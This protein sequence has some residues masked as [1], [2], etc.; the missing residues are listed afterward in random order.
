MAR[1]KGLEGPGKPL[2]H[3]SGSSAIADKAR[4]DYASNHVFRFLLESHDVS[5]DRMNL[6]E[7]WACWIQA[8]I[9]VG[10]VNRFF[11]PTIQ[12]LGRLGC[13][14]L[15]EDSKHSIALVRKRESRLRK[16]LV[17]RRFT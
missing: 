17:N 12:G 11:M 5:H 8:S 1:I 7:R 16:A 13:E 4:D 14:I 2:L 6:D 15:L 3:T 10:A 9:A